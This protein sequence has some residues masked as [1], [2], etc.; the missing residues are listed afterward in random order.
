MGPIAIVILALLFLVALVSVGS[1]CRIEIGSLRKHPS[2]ESSYESDLLM[3]WG[4]VL[5][6]AFALGLVFVYVIQRP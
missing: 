6:A 1:I 3:I 4:L 5:V 2:L